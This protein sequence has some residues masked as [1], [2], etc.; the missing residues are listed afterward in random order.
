M[1]KAGAEVP[2]CV[3][4][5]QAGAEDHHGLEDQS[6]LNVVADALQRAV[7]ELA[8]WGVKI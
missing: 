8:R 1:D 3:L 6:H 5:G 4:P 7:N 2:V